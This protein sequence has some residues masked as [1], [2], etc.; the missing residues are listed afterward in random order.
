MGSTLAICQS[1]SAGRQKPH[2]EI[3]NVNYIPQA[4]EQPYTPDESWMDDDGSDKTMTNL[5]IF[6][7]GDM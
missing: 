3:V 6:I 1:T 4:P 7:T 2:P 5:G